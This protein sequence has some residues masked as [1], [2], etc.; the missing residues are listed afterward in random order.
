[1]A[2]RSVCGEFEYN[3]KIY[4]FV[5]QDRMMTV[6]QSAFHYWNDF[7]GK[8]DLGTL[9][10]V[11]DS[12]KFIL[13]LD[14]RV[15]N[16][17]TISLSGKV[18]IAIHGYILQDKREDGY[19]RIKFCSPALNVFYSPR[20]AWTPQIG[21]GE[22]TPG[23]T[24]NPY[25]DSTR[26][27]VVCVGNEEIQC[28]LDFEWN[29]NLRF[30]ECNAMSVKTN[31]S[32]SFENQKSASEL[33]KYYLYLRDF[34][35][36]LNFRSDIPFDEITLWCHGEDGKFYK[37]G[38]AEIFQ[39]KDI[40]YDSKA[41]NTI[42]ADDLDDKSFVALFKEIAEQRT[43]R[44]YNPYFIPSN[45]TESNVVDRAK[46]LVTAISFE[47][48]FNKRYKDIKTEQSSDFQRVKMLLLS[49][50]DQTVK[51]TGFGINNPR[52]EELKSFRK[53]I[54][55]YDTTIKEK[56]EFCATH[57]AAEIEDVQRRYCD[58]TGVPI[59]TDFAKKY[60][61]ARNR[62]AHGVIE[63]LEDVDIVIFL[64]LRCFI[65]LLIMERADIS[66]A[67]MKEIIAKLF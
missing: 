18:L 66:P 50:I 62:S 19:D 2:E 1:M 55:R 51:K 24:L 5:I 42:I 56:Y 13:L 53:L 60:A 63:P 57:F 45:K 58:R 38:K 29:I 11:T 65:Y 67:K 3:G 36:F 17:Q 21:G 59:D 14:C 25:R 46:W 61:E 39:T 20:K 41:Q 64:I 40:I 12:N 8:E 23:L 43:Q 15:W 16:Q 37:S 48:E 27:I 44:N 35:S 52:N 32:M 28:T 30:E 34:L 49:T 10:G 26:Q 33:G 7:M 54:E 6:V 4:P 9:V 47:G 31:F 22:E